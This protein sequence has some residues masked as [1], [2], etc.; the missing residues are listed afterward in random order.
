MP[1]MFRFRLFLS[2]LA[3]LGSL[4]LSASAERIVQGDL[5]LDGIPEIPADLI[6]RLDP[7]LNTR[8]ASFGGWRNDGDGI[9]ILTRFG[10]TTQV[11]AVHNPGGARRQL[12]F[13]PERVSGIAIPRNEQRP[14]FLFGRDEG[15]NEQFQLYAFDSRTAVATRYTDGSS[16]NGG[17]S[18][19]PA[20]TRLA[21][22]STARTGRDWD[23][24]LADLGDPDS[25]TL[26]YEASGFF[27]PGDFSPDGERLLLRQFVSSAESYI[28]ILDLA[29][30]KA[31]PIDTAPATDGT[32]SYG[33]VIWAPDG[34]HLFLVSD[35]DDE[36]SLLRK[37]H[38]ESGEETLLT[39]DIPW[40]VASIALS[41][42]G[43]HLAISV[44][45][46]GLN[47]LYLLDTTTMER[48]PAADL[49][50]GIISGLT[51]D[52]SGRHLGFTFNTPRSPGDAYSLDVQTGELTRWTYSEAGGLDTDTFTFPELIHYPTF[53]EVDGAPRK[54]P[55][56][57][58]RPEG[59][60]PF[61]VLIN[62]HGGPAAQARPFF[63]AVREFMIR[64]LGMAVI[65]PNVRGSTG[66]GK[67]F[68]SLDD[69][70]LREDAVRDIGALLDWIAT[71]DDL[72][73]SRVIT[74]GGSYGG[75]MVYASH[76]HFGDR[77]AAG[78][79]NVGISHFVT[80]LESTAEYRRDLRR[81]EYGDERDPEMRAFLHEISP[82]TQ[83]H[84]IR[85]PML[86]GQGFN[87][88]RV[89]YTEAEQI[90]QR[91]REN[92]QEVWYFLAMNEGHGFARRSNSDAY[93]RTVMYFLQTHIT[94]E[95]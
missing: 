66:Y 41:E 7:Y 9:L 50:P 60:G 39:G 19:N 85:R 24:Y 48:R 64:E 22:Y 86:I 53:D 32:I 67:T 35:R 90:V 83:A 16:R 40:N 43:A 1:G 65:T 28:H 91:I 52:P 78:V 23:I 15:G 47:E 69:G 58:Y 70:F 93:F 77:L 80:F 46:D 74:Y 12:T 25:V 92:G 56:F 6:A 89:P 49:P 55:A 3:L 75:Y 4:P 14:G 62:I 36:F 8:A 38:I 30:G 26:V 21:F 45:A 27:V 10:E 76:V 88:P 57:V 31:T 20:G 37:H 68:V 29:S 17:A 42:D 11:H 73:P 18:I 82:L 5:V 79:S 71:Q 44:N 63:S 13:F 54:I 87:D 33:S 84:R 72:D 81:P 61:P 34:E 94:R 51:W 59:E 95:P 2:G